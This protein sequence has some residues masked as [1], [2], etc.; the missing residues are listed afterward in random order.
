MLGAHQ[1]VAFV[2]TSDPDRARTFYSEVL[3]LDLVDD[4]PYALVF[5]AGGT[6]L[7]VQKV[8]RHIP[9]GYTVLGWSVADLRAAV[10]DLSGRGV[11]FER[12]EHLPQDE[13]G[14][15]TTGEGA[16]VAWFKDP[17]GNVLSLV[18]HPTGAP[19]QSCQGPYS[20]PS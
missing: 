10:Q 9:L 11:F 19:A 15:W 17:D 2:A 16:M 13:Y 7:R 12:Y 14:A 5:E 8:P 6:T 4:Q 3:G 1:M 20:S 18:Q